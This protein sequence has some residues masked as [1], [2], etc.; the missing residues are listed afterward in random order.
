MENLKKKNK[1]T[2]P[3]MT[4]YIKH[5]LDSSSPLFQ[6]AEL[7]RR[8]VTSHIGSKV[9]KKAACSPERQI[10]EHEE[11]VSEGQS[12]QYLQYL[13]VVGTKLLQ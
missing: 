9:G 7:S 3:E 8:S 2:R 6:Q 1:R 10:C 13:L 12:R 4:R 11:R 5:T